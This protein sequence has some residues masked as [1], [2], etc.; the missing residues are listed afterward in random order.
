MS[1]LFSSAPGLKS[2][3]ASVVNAIKR[4]FDSIAT[5][6]ETVDASMSLYSES[7]LAEAFGGEENVA[8]LV[9]L[10][11]ILGN[12]QGQLSAPTATEAAQLSDS[13]SKAKTAA[14][15]AAEKAAAKAADEEAAKKAADEA[16]K[17]AADEAARK[18]G[19]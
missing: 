16:A 4:A 5:E 13:K 8:E 9:R 17:K 7:D 3:P 15:K 12:A 10:R 1:K 14:E 2:V 19:Q 6:L 11:T 18:A